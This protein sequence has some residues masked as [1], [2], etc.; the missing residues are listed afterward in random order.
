MRGHQYG[1]DCGQ[2]AQNDGIIFILLSVCHVRMAVRM[3]ILKTLRMLILKNIL[4][5]SDTREE[6]MLR[7]YFSNAVPSQ[8]VSLK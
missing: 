4:K 3:Y 8:L 2:V 6:N 1:K 7:R 5:Y